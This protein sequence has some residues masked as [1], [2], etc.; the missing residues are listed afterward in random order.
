MMG[1]PLDETYYQRPKPTP[2]PEPT[3]QEPQK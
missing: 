2:K 3:D 1:F